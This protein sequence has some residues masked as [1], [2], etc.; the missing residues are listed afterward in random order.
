MC[1][2]RRSCQLQIASVD[3]FYCKFA[4][5]SNLNLLPIFYY[6]QLTEAEDVVLVEGAEGVAMEVVV[7]VEGAEGVAMEVVAAAVVEEGEFINS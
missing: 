7:L 6:S 3:T 2:E 5:L 1:A 4:Y